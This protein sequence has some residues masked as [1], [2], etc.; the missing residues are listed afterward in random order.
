MTNRFAILLSFFLLSLSLM[1]ISSRFFYREGSLLLYVYHDDILPTQWEETTPLRFI[2]PTMGKSSRSITLK[3]LCRRY[4]EIEEKEAC[5]LWKIILERAETTCIHG[6]Q[7]NRSHCEIGKTTR[8][9]HLVTGPML[10]LWTCFHAF[11]SNEKRLPWTQATIQVEEGNEGNTHETSQS[12]TERKEMRSIT[13]VR[14]PS[15][16]SDEMKKKL[17]DLEAQQHRERKK[18]SIINTHH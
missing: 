2:R 10:P 5:A 7:C 11:I 6:P 12:M 13:G 14:I 4:H 16:I 3:S 1:F 17:K 8:I 15:A 18:S 9:V